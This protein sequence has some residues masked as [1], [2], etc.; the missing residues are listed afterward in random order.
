MDIVYKRGGSAIANKRC[1][2]NL[3]FVYKRKLNFDMLTFYRR[4][5]I[6]T[7]TLNKLFAYLAKECVHTCKY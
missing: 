6:K 5:T 2:V 4:V 1:T 7:Q 3:H